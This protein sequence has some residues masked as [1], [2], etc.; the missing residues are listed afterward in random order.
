MRIKIYQI[1]TERDL[2][3]V[4]FE[5]YENLPKIQG[6]ENLESGIY[7]LVFEG[8]VPCR[9]LEEVFEMF[10]CNRPVGYKGRSVSVSDVI[11]DTDSHRFFFCD[12][13]D[14]R[15]VAFHSEACKISEEFLKLNEPE[16]IDVL[17]VRTGRE[18]E[19]AV[20]EN[21]PEA[22]RKIVGEKT[23]QIPLYGDQTVIV[24]SA[25][26]SPG[27]L[28]P[29]RAVYAEPKEKDMAY[30]EMKELFQNTDAIAKK[31]LTG[32]IVFS[33]DSFKK[34]YSL[35]SRTY[36]VS[37]D[38]KAFY[39]SMSGYSIFGDSLD[40][41]DNGVRLDYY[42]ADERAGEDGW[43]IERCYIKNE[44]RDIIA[45]DFFIACASNDGGLKSLPDD[46]MKKYGEMFRSPERFVKTEKGIEV[47]PI[48][49]A[50]DAWERN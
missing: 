30:R 49:P 31:F 25:G 3:R 33:Q 39:N 43:K 40:G 15:E 12:N 42:M 20:V 16:K 11:E 48:K 27:S 44:V 1:N 7:D 46:L 21:S 32:Y 37:A 8:D 19:K 22:I 26:G 45:G 10:N 14:F 35:E 28:P 2:N 38:N 17:L 36:A 6:S 29:N 47:I 50:K 34:P 41:S 13:V 24:R 23:E 9:N 4:A 5:K 18:P